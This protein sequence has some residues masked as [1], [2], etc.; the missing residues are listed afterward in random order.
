MAPNAS[1]FLAGSS[2][3]FQCSVQLDNSG[4][5]DTPVMVTTLWERNDEVLD[6]DSRITATQ[7][8]SDVY[9]YNSVLEFSTL[10]S[11]QDPGD[12]SCVVT[13]IPVDEQFVTG[14]M[15]EATHS[16]SVT[17]GCLHCYLHIDNSYI[18]CGCRPT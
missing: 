2:I 10:S 8:Q 16:L 11:T 7:T 12:Y 18:K 3:T 1:S 9:R 15:M 5:I 17:G 13:I 4:V 14:S 6:G